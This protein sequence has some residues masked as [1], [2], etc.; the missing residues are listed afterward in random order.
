LFSLLKFGTL[1][2]FERIGK[3]TRQLEAKT[4]QRLRA[5]VAGNIGCQRRNRFQSFSFV[6]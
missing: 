5:D 2:A 4:T 1:A 3:L 6:S